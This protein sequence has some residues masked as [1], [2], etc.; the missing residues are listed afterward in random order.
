[1]W[2][3]WPV[4][5]AATPKST[6]AASAGQSRRRYS[7]HPASTRT[8]SGGTAIADSASWATPPPAAPLT[9]ASPVA[10]A[11]PTAVSRSHGPGVTLEMAHLPQLAADVPK[12]AG[13]GHV[14]NR[15]IEVLGRRRRARVPLERIG[16]P[17]IVR[18]TFA[19]PARDDHVDEE[20]EDAEAHDPGADARGEV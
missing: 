20:E 19:A 17:G 11:A 16:Q 3:T 15:S 13:A 12:R 2:A 1:M 8:T 7:N 4:T 9:T 14:R 18:R 10:T 5:S 6:S